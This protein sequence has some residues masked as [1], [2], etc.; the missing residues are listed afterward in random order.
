ME[1]LVADKGLPSSVSVI[2][3][4]ANMYAQEAGAGSQI[5]AVLRI[6]G[7]DYEGSTI[8]LSSGTLQCRTIFD[9]SPDTDDAWTKNEIEAIEV[10]VK[11]V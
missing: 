3:V 10:G 11:L 4:S 1:E 7:T 2:A 6:N 5:K 8:T 9:E